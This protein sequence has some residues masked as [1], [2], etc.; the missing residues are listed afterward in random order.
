MHN[1]GASG[2]APLLFFAS[3]ALLSIFSCLALA[4]MTRRTRG[5]TFASHD[6]FW[7][8][9]GPVV[10]SLGVA[11]LVLLVPCCHGQ[12]MSSL[13]HGIGTRDL[14]LVGTAMT[15]AVV[16]LQAFVKTFWYFLKTEIGTKSLK[17]NCFSPTPKL[18]TALQKLNRNN[19]RNLRCYEIEGACIP[20]A[21]LGW[22]FPWVAISSNLVKGLSEDEL[23]G[24]LWH[25][26][27]HAV[28]RDNVRKLFSFFSLQVIGIFP[29]VRGLNRLWEESTELGCD[30]FAVQKTG[31]PLDLAAALLVAAKERL[32]RP[33][34]S[35]VSGLFHER[36]GV[37]GRVEAI[38]GQHENAEPL[39]KPA[40]FLRYWLAWSAAWL[41]MLTK[42]ELVPSVWCFLAS[43]WGR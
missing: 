2:M 4:I 14:I 6:Y 5:K 12:P 41:F 13:H 18:E 17:G 1:L 31:R 8:L 20:S 15:L 32:R 27:H 42:L 35:L 22:F 24:I 33:D 26:F 39:W 9:N 40:G 29:W 23:E 19:H 37:V 36:R 38:L 30:Q 10:V 34:A 16:L 43:H 28:S 21:T 7:A 3:S 25:E 11:F